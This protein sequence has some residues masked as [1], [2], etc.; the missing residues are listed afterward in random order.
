MPAEGPAQSVRRLRT[1][2]H[3][4]DFKQCDAHHAPAVGLLLLLQ[5]AESAGT[6]L[7]HCMSD[8]AKLGLI[9]LFMVFALMV[10]GPVIAG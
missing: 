3:E 7:E 4:T 10:I 6:W 2:R 8:D 9:L 1:P 5:R